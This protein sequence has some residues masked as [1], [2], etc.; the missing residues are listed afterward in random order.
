[1]NAQSHD[2]SGV[3]LDQPFH[4]FGSL[5]CDR[6]VK[7]GAFEE[8]GRGIMLEAV[9]QVTVIVLIGLRMNH[10]GM[11]NAGYT[12]ESGVVFHRLRLGLVRCVVRKGKALRIEQMDV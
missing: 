7:T 1:M 3:L 11:A 6:I 8:T 9:S 2:A 5:G 10:D 4:V 12:G